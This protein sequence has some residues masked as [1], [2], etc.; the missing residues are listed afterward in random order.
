LIASP[1]SVPMGSPANLTW[2]I[3]SGASCAATGG[4]NGDGWTGIFTLSGSQ[5]VTY[6]APNSI[7]YG[8]SCT[9]G[10]QTAQASAVVTY[11]A[12]PVAVSVNASPNSFTAG[13]SITITWQSTNA[14]SCTGS[15][16][17]ASDGWPG[18]KATT[19]SQMIIEPYAPAG[20]SLSLEFT[21]ACTS[22]I[23]SL[24]NSASVTVVENAAPSKGG[25][26]GGGLDAVALV[27]LFL[28]LLTRF[29]LEI[30][31]TKG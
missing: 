12:L 27:S 8:L 30:A 21:V 25:G 14:T 6:A 15:G 17:G 19:G 18:A 9:A 3:S 28:L 10:S 29:Q 4:V 1:N 22:N 31:P 20:S 13:Q 7:T 24:S 23:S 2:K 5:T 11:T 16:G 26:G